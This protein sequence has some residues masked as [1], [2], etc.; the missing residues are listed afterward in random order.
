MRTFVL[1]ALLVRALNAQ[2]DEAITPTAISTATPLADSDAFSA[3]PILPAGT[4]DVILSTLSP[5]ASPIGRVGGLPSLPSLPGFPSL[6]QPPVLPLRPIS[7]PVA[8]PS[9][10]GGFR[11]LAFE[12]PQ[13]LAGV[14]AGVGAGVN[15]NPLLS[16]SGTGKVNILAANDPGNI[17]AQDYD[18]SSEYYTPTRP[19]PPGWDG[20][21]NGFYDGEDYDTAYY[22]AKQKGK[23]DDYCPS[24]CADYSDS[25]D[26]DGVLVKKKKKVARKG[27][28]DA[29]GILNATDPVRRSARPQDPPSR[30]TGFKWP[31]KVADGK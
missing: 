13:P 12:Q 25:D 31:K 15:A 30:I 17:N 29:S 16:G 11:P 26:E 28:L 10:A 23:G 1:G 6:S 14:G 20:E 18:P 9:Q 2:S 3:L 22:W 21:D 4:N 19:G 5:T 27:T 24:W 8:A 7:S